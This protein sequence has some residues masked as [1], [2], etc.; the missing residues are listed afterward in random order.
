MASRIQRLDLTVEL[1]TTP[2]GNRYLT[3]R[4]ESQ[5]PHTTGQLTPRVKRVVANQLALNPGTKFATVK[6]NLDA[7]E[8]M[9]ALLEVK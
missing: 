9:A 6:L 1:T 3:I 7:G 5:Q 8:L 2:R 4:S